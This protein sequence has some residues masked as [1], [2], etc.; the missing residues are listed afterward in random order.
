MAD[1]TDL[2]A[3]RGGG[4]RERVLAGEALVGTL[5]TSGS[6][7]FAEICARAG[8]DWVMADLEHGAGTEA[9]LLGQLQGIQGG[10]A[11]GLVRVQQAS[12]IAIGRALDLGAEGIM[13][14]RLES[15]EEARQV[16][17]WLRYPPA[18]ERGVALFTRGARLGTVAHESI[19]ELNE[20][21]VGI[22]QVENRAALAAAE[23]VA[24][25]D[26]VDVLFVGPT[27]L[28]HSLGVPGRLDEQ[29]YREAVTTVGRAAKRHGKAAGVLV[30]AAEDLERY[31]EEGFRFFAI[32][33]DGGILNR[34]ARSA[35]SSSRQLLERYG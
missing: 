15:L 22:V 27:D 28:S 19:R 24:A 23:E 21:V 6:A 16:V 1:P 33:S 4:I 12:R 32:S 14:P 35:V 18:G 11:A 20:R 5:L 26:G 10:G 29:P 8:F 2:Q 9:D 34:A 25:L 31:A 30:W 3:Q 17:S 13:V 7:M